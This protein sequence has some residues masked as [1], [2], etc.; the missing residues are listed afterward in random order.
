MTYMPEN[1]Y[2]GM[3]IMEHQHIN[4][5]L[6]EEHNISILT[7]I[8]TAI[9]NNDYITLYLNELYISRISSNYSTH[10]VLIHGYDDE[11]NK[12]YLMAFDNDNHRRY[13]EITCTYDEFT[14][15]YY[16]TD[17]TIDK[18]SI[19]I[20]LIHIN[21]HEK[22]DFDMHIMREWL[23][24]YLESRNSVL[25]RQ[26]RHIIPPNTP[27]IW[28]R[29]CYLELIKR[30]EKWNN[31][32][33]R[34]LY[35]IYEHKNIMLERIK[36]MFVNNYITGCENLIEKYDSIVQKSLQIKN[37]TIKSDIK[38]TNYNADKYKEFF[39][40]IY[41]EEYILLQELLKKVNNNYDKWL[42]E[43]NLINT[44]R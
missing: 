41:S 23:I 35:C 28:G 33:L 38:N 34:I 24:D 31:I 8:K 16:E 12:L 27:T 30:A 6:L 26:S 11:N 42:Y 13:G 4:R 10:K 2:T 36:F 19:I 43:E 7:F 22:Y 18:N 14:N 20:N 9:D 21:P 37:Y 3:E 40:Y 39:K 29:N 15:A 1:V 17:H 32:D 44:K 25:K 5:K